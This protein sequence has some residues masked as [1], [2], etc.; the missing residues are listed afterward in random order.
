MERLNQIIGHLSVDMERFDEK[1]NRKNGTTV[2][3][4]LQSL[5]NEC[6]SLR[7]D[8][9]E[10]TKVPLPPVVEEPVGPPNTPE[11]EPVGPVPESEPAPV[12]ESEP[13]PVPKEKKKKKRKKVVK[14]E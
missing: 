12:P 9:L 1:T 8:I 2:R 10:R 11:P 14:E 4:T 13:A 7:K 6:H 3:K 5:K